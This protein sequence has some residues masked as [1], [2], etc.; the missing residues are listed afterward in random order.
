MKPYIELNIDGVLVPLNTT[1]LPFLLSYRIA[2]E[3]GKV[4]GSSSDRFISLPASKATNN[5]YQAYNEIGAN[6]ED[7]I[8]YKPTTVLVNGTP[9]FSGVSQLQR[10]VLSGKGRPYKREVSSYKVGLFGQN[11]DWLIKLK[12]LKLSDLDFTNAVFDAATVQSGFNASYDGGD[13]FG[14]C[15]IKWRTWNNETGG[16]T[17]RGAVSVD[18]GEFTPFLFVRA[19]LEKIFDFIGVNIDSNLITTERFKSLILPL[20]PIDVYPQTYSED[21][22]N[23]T[24]QLNSFL[25]TA[26]N[27][28]APAL[29]LTAIKLPPLNTGAWVGATSTYT[30]LNS[31]F[32]YVDADLTVNAIG[33]PNTMEFLS[34]GFSI[35]GGTF[36]AASSFGYLLG[37]GTVFVGERSKNKTIVLP[38]TAG[39]TIQIQYIAIATGAG[40]STATLDGTL[41]F[42]FEAS[43]SLGNTISWKYL[44]KDWTAL[45]FINGLTDVHNLRFE[46][47]PNTQTINL[48]PRNNYT[49]T[50][51]LTPVTLEQ[52]FYDDST[53]KDYTQK[54]DFYKGAELSKLNP[55]RNQIFKW[56]TDGPTESKLEEN[57]KRGIYEGAYILED[58]T[59]IDEEDEKEIRFFA[60]TIHINDKL[61]QSDPNT[62][63]PNVAPLIPLIFPNDYQ[64]NDEALEG[65]YEI[66]PR[67]LHFFGQRGGI[68]GFIQV[69]G[70]GDVETPA[71]FFTNYNDNTGLDPSLSFAN[72]IVNG[73]TIT[74]LLDV[75]YIHEL[76]T[77]GKAKKLKEWL[78]WST[79]DLNKLSFKNTL[80]IDSIRYLLEEVQDF[81]PT[82]D[83]STKT[84]LTPYYLAEVADTNNIENTTLKGLAVLFP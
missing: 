77:L 61:I 83:L 51:Q 69:S 29:G 52:G 62:V 44:L 66:K 7:A 60:K 74:G 33:G 63:G 4:A 49:D 39:D 25:A 36:Q 19:I 72:E 1:D 47:N 15:C 64:D 42:I 81:D 24:V 50:S 65:S 79:L 13:F 45:D 20:P 23:F 31:G 26:P 2:D 28:G 54:L 75:F 80:L 37:G 40:V 56:A 27:V 38:I 73:N 70:V 11:A 16:T 55:K 82:Q 84:I 43:F 32:F 14:F 53:T 3:L 17:A 46:Y 12:G 48:D 30:V 22:L 59:F 67:L 10:A 8:K 6:N 18:L 68:D 71:C 9:V 5:L 76:V 35:N 34:V 21:Y 58:N 57:Q 78:T 41:N